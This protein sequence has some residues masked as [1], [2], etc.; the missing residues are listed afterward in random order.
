MNPIRRATADFAGVL[1]RSTPPD[2]AAS[3]AKLVG[4]TPPHTPVESRERKRV[5]TGRRRARRRCIPDSAPTTVAAAEAA[6]RAALRT[7]A[8]RRRATRRRLITTVVVGVA[9]V[10][11]VMATRDNQAVRRC[12]ASAEYAAGVFRAE[13]ARHQPLP[14][15]FPRPREG[16]IMPREHY[17]YSPLNAN[18]I[19][20][21]RPIGICYCEDR[22]NLFLQADGRHVLLYDGERIELRWVTEPEFVRQAEAWGFEGHAR[23]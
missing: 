14:L 10:L 2:A 16:Q 13:L 18:L 1:A 21:R 6:E 8:A 7:M 23:H 11:M 12:R 15:S 20:L 19:A 4:F 22:H 17:H 3:L 5:H 9:M